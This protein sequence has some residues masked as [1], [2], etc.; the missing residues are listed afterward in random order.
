MIGGPVRPLVCHLLPK[1]AGKMNHTLSAMH[2]SLPQYKLL[3]LWKLHAG[4]LGPR[5]C[6]LLL[7]GTM[8]LSGRAIVHSAASPTK[9]SHCL[10]PYG[11]VWQRTQTFL[12]ESSP[13][14]SDSGQFSGKTTWCFQN[15]VHQQVRVELVP[16]CTPLGGTGLQQLLLP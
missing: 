4:L 6:M 9:C 11:I 13:S 7:G 16:T 12:I 3:F 5:P 2:A 8:C 14:V 1:E 10:Q 15:L